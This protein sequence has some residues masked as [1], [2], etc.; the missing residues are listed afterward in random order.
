MKGTWK[1]LRKA[2][3]KEAKQSVIEAIFFI[4]EK[5][6]TSKEFLT[7]LVTTLLQLVRRLLRISRNCPS[8]HWSICQKLTRMRILSLKC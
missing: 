3:N 5:S 8:L 4:T 7:S 6:M 1:T 2:M